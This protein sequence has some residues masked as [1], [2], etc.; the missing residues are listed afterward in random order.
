MLALLCRLQ[1]E[2]VRAGRDG[3]PGPPVPQASLSV[4]WWTWWEGAALKKCQAGGHPSCILAEVT[5][6][7]PWGA[8]SNL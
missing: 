6:S 3:A 1:A 5:M 7:S 2:E 4:P 8:G